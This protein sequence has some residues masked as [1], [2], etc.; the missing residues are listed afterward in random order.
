MKRWLSFIGLLAVVV[1]GLSVLNGR[2]GSE[3][4]LTEAPE[5]PGWYLKDAVM[6][7]T[8]PTGE[9]RVKIAA[10]LI[11]QDAARDTIDMNAVRVDYFGAPSRHWLLIA[12]R[13][14][15]PAHEQSVMFSGEVEVE[16]VGAANSPRILT[17]RLLLDMRKDIA[18]TDAD[19]NVVFGTHSVTARGLYA[20]LNAQS[21]RLQSNVNGRFVPK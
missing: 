12:N 3:V 16:E 5:Q 14:H 21:L 15:V 19:V 7:E 20:D 13:G 11:Q 1:I 8:T 17:E 9:P 6:I 10:E 4:T 18:R 2:E